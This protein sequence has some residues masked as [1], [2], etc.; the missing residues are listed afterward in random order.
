MQ[1]SPMVWKKYTNTNQIILTDAV[2]APAGMDAE[3]M[4]TQAIPSPNNPIPIAYFIFAFGLCLLSHHLENRGAKVIMTSEFNVPNQE[5]SISATS[6]LNLSYNLKIEI[7]QIIT[8]LVPK[9]MFDNE[10]LANVFRN[11]LIKTQ[12][13]T[14]RG[15]TVS[16][17]STIL[18]IMAAFPSKILLV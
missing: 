17:T 5:A 13:I 9:N 15:T 16:N 11:S 4:A 18:K 1:S 3:P 14:P 6:P 8:K 10:Y 7:P 12:V 2:F